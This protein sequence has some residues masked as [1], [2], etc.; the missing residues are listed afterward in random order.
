MTISELIA[1]LESLRDEH[2]DL[3]VILIDSEYDM[4]ELDIEC[5]KIYCN[6]GRKVVKFYH[7]DYTE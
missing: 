5:E 4:C 3:D 6:S 7:G 2:G 1:N